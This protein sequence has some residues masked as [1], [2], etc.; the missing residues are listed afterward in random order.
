MGVG[1]GVTVV[2]G[3]G[4]GE[5]SIA[6][7]AKSKP[8]STDSVGDG[9]GDGDGLGVAEAGVGLG[10]PEVEPP[11]PG[12]ASISLCIRIFF[13]SDLL[14]QL[15]YCFAQNLDLSLDKV[16]CMMN[17][18]NLTLKILLTQSLVQRGKR[19][20]KDRLLPYLQLGIEVGTEEF[21]SDTFA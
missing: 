9:E 16:S 6:S 13:I 15:R 4:A 14:L 12:V 20:K 3:A 18:S 8:A 11:V 19:F 10:V 21:K 2:A 7:D 17:T 5:S 1:A